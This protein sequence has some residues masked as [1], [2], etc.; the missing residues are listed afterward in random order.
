MLSNNLILCYPL[1]LLPSIFPSISIFSDELALHIRWP[2][3]WSFSVS[4]TPSNEYSWSVSFRM[5]W[6]DLLAVQGIPKSLFQRHGS[7]T[8]NLDK[9]QFS[10]VQFSCSV[11]SDCLQPY[12]IQHTRPPCL[13]PTRWTWDWVDSGNWWWTGRPGVLRF[14]GLQ[15]VR[16]DWATELNKLILSKINS[17]FLIR[18]HEI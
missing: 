6:I 9:P 15:T 14:M 10:S 7:K 11:V 12:E 18:N 4:I 17:I 5:D 16:H 13:S 3:C 1:L 2:K 8:S